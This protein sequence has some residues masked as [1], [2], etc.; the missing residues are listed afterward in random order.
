[1]APHANASRRVLAHVIPADPKGWAK[2]RSV[3]ST[4]NAKG[5]VADVASGVAT[6]VADGVG[7]DA[8]GADA[9]VAACFAVQAAARNTTAT[10][11]ARTG[12]DLIAPLSSSRARSVHQSARRAAR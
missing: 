6:D 5:A 4:P 11:M 12:A 3:Y 8:A 2:P 9:G 10:A 7:A 1:M